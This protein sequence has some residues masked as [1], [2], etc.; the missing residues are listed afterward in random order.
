MVLR[1]DLLILGINLGMLK[2]SVP[3][4]E[5]EGALTEHSSNAQT[6]HQLYRFSPRSFG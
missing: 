4:P 2:K 5:C 6:A 3:E 1:L